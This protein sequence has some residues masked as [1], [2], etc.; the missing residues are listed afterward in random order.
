[1]KKMFLA[2]MLAATVTVGTT[3]ITY[4]Q[5][6]AP[7]AA[8]TPANTKPAE[9]APADGGSFWSVVVGSGFVGFMLWMALFGSGAAAAYF[10]VD[11]F[12]LVRP[13]K[14]MPQE[15]IDSVQEAMN[16]GDVMKALD[17]CAADPSS[18]SK[19]LT[20]GFS[21]VTEGFD[22]IEEAVQSAAELEVEGLMQRLNWIS[23]CANLAPMLGLLGTVQGMILTFAG[24]AKSTGAPE[25]SMLALTISQALYTTAGGLVVAIPAVA[26]FYSLRNSANRLILRMQVLTTDLVKNLRNV[27][28]EA[29]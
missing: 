17:L 24:L 19:I 28:V 6:A 22:V 20:A 14:I 13:K 4:A 25:M 8:A 15:L 27:E 29:E 10:I 18:L 23:V 11:G 1:M 2:L 12:I 9:E 7:A 5:D 26:F 16:E 21:H 3:A